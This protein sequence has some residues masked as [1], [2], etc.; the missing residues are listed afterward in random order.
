MR[1][2][3]SSKLSWRNA[4]P[5]VALLTTA[6]LLLVLSP[7]LPYRLSAAA[8]DLADGVGRRLANTN[9]GLCLDVPAA[10]QADGIKLQQWGCTG[11]TAQSW[12]FTAT[13]G[14]F[15]TLRN[16][17]S[18]KCLDVPYASP[19]P[20]TQLQQVVCNGSDAQNWQTVESATGFQVKNKANGLC[21]AVKDA[22]LTNT[23][24]IVQIACAGQPAQIWTISTL[25]NLADGVSR[26]AVNAN[27]GLCLDVPASSQA[28]GIKLQQWECNGAA[29]QN[30]TFTGTGDGFYT[31]KNVN[32]G[33]CLDVPYASPDPGTQLQQV[34]CNDADAQSWQ[35]LELS[36]GTR[37]KNKASNL[38]AAVKDAA[39]T[40]MA[41]IVQVA[42]AAG[43]AQLWAVI[44]RAPLDLADGVGRRAVNINSG[45]CLDVPASSQA[46]GIK[47][48]QW[49]CNGA[50]G[51]NW[52][53]TGT[54]DGFYTLK[55]VN[56]GKCLDVPYASPD[57]GTQLQQVV[58]NDADAQS[59]Q[60]LELSGGT[61]LKNKA[62]NLCAA[63]KDAALTNMAQII[64]IACATKDAQIW[65]ITAL[66]GL[67]G[68]PT[69]VQ[70]TAGDRQATVTW[71]APA[72][73]GG[74]ALTG[75]TVTAT[76]GGRTATVSGQATTAT[77]TGLTNGTNY[78]F[79]VVA[80]NAAG[81][82]PASQPSPGVTPVGP[83]APPTA[84]TATAGDRQVIVTWTAPADTGGS[85][86][87]GYTVTTTPGN[88]A[89]TVAG[90]TLT[91][92][93]TG[94]TNGTSYTF[95]VKAKN[96][97]GTGT[98][99]ASSSPATP[100]TTP[101]AP[102]NVTANGGDGKATVSWTAPADTG[103]SPITGYTVTTT[104]GGT[105]LVV[106][107]DRTSATVT[108]LAN[109]TT[110]TF[111]VTAR[112]T[113]GPGPE[114]AP[115][116]PVIPAPGLEAPTDVTAVPGDRQATVSWTAPGGTVTGY[117]ITAAPG[118]RTATVSGQATT[119]TVTGLTNGTAYTF[120]VVATN[121][122]T[123]GPASQPSTAVTPAGPPGAPTTVTVEGG[124][125][126]A[127]VSW[128]AP[129]DTGGKP[130]TG[131]TV[132][133]TPG[134]RTATVSGQ[135]TTATVTGLTNGTAYTFTVTAT[136]TAGTSEP[137]A[138]S[139]SVTPIGKPSPPTA[140]TA[141]AGDG[142]A[143]V[144][145]QAPVNGGSTI[146][147]YTVTATPGNATATVAGTTLTATVGG[148]TNGTAYTF[149][150]TATNAADTS[151]PSEPSNPVTP[152]VQAPPGAPFITDV[153]PR[154]GAVRVSWTPPDTGASGLTRYVVTATPGAASVETAPGATET[155]VTGL[156]NGTAY[157]F[158]VTAFN[159]VGEGS[160][161]WPSN[162][163]TP[164]P[165]KVPLRPAGVQAFP[166]DRRIDV[167]WVPVGD[168][169][170]PITG[171]VV[172]AQPGDV[173]VE[174]EATDTT[175]S[176][177]GLT[178]GTAYT[179]TV[180]ARNSAGDSTSSAVEAVTPSA[181]R[182]P[183]APEQVLVGVPT[184]GTA[185]ISWKPPVDTGTGPVTG[186]TVTA[187]PG[188]HS[189]TTS[190]ATT[191]ATVSGLNPET[192][193]AFTVRAANASGNG[194]ASGATGSIIPKVTVKRDP[195][196]L[197]QAALATLRDVRD[198]RTLV[199]HNPPAQVTGLTLGDIVIIEDSPHAPE[200]FL[201]K[202]LS[203][204]A[205]GEEFIVSTTTSSLDEIF[206][207]AAFAMD[208]RL[209]A[210]Q[211]EFI[212]SG[213][214]ARVA[215]AGP[216]TPRAFIR[217]PGVLVVDLSWTLRDRGRTTTQLNGW[218]TVDPSFKITNTLTSNLLDY[219][220]KVVTETSVKLSSELRLDHGFRRGFQEKLTLGVVKGPCF[221]VKIRGVPV[222]VCTRFYINYTVS[223][224]VS[225][226]LSYAAHLDREVGV[227]C[228]ASG[229]ATE[230]GCEIFENEGPGFW[231]D[232]CTGPSVVN[233]VGLYGDGQISTGIETD[234]ALMLYGGVGPALT[235]TF[236]RFDLKTSTTQNPWCELA[237]LVRVGA[238]L[239]ARIF[240]KTYSPW[241][242]PDLIPLAGK[243]LV[244]G[245]TFQGLKINP[246][247]GQVAPGLSLQFDA[248]VS[249][250]PDNV[251]K[252]WAV[253]KGPGTINQDGLYTAGTEQGV[254]E[255]EVVSPATGGHPELRARAAVEVGTVYG[256]PSAPRR[257][258]W[259]R[260]GQRSI[261]ASWQRPVSQGSSA[262]SGYVVIAQPTASDD[263]SDAITAYAPGN[264]THALVQNLAP[265]ETYRITVYARNAQ[266]TSLPSESEEITTLDLTFPAP[267]TQGN[268]LATSN[269]V[270]RG[271]PDSTN[272][273]LG[274]IS[275]DGRYLFYLTQGRSN[276][277]VTPVANPANYNLYLF[278]YDTT[279]TE[280]IVVS[281]G[282]TGEAVTSAYIF[283]A[284][285]DGNT[286]AFLN[287]SNLI[288][289]RINAGTS[290]SPGT[291]L[292]PYGVSNNGD[293][294]LYRKKLAGTTA[295]FNAFRQVAGGA[296]QQMDEECT[297]GAADEKCLDLGATM[298]DDGSKVAYGT[299][300]NRDGGN[301]WRVWVFDAA[302]GTR[303]E[304]TSDSAVPRVSNPIISGDG[305][306]VAVSYTWW[307]RSPASEPLVSGLALKR[308]GTG[309]VTRADI[310]VPFVS[311]TSGQGGSA[312]QEWA[313]PEVLSGDGQV[314]AYHH[315]T[316]TGTGIFD[317]LHSLRTYRVGGMT[318]IAG[319][320]ALTQPSL[321]SLTD[322]GQR[323]VYTLTGASGSG[324]GLIPGV[325]HDL[326]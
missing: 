103:G 213:P 203:A 133:A 117:T 24:Q 292:A 100:N 178:N 274:V 13:P 87:T 29:G 316:K 188:G 82:G 278:R 59:W 157:T 122:Q 45:L 164:E 152:A 277:A 154:D 276:L 298:S 80:A 9:S 108:G 67:P 227:R 323:L 107:A 222:K 287:G 30:W 283:K 324:L 238:A 204:A 299:I 104:P 138:P 77:V 301:E 245:D 25:V 8:A 220:P 102:T 131:Y 97:V 62:S 199:F 226:G 113:A 289:H 318:H 275:G 98:A 56:S 147:G 182:P 149:T 252:N 120:T 171:Y 166:L 320:S 261:T 192:A 232:D 211:M 27:S 279:T 32:S 111:T 264:A 173:T 243:S 15:Y 61:R 215:A 19:D 321:I 286:V 156:T 263:A 75:Y 280:R 73:T 10:S 282:L 159:T 167:Q 54:G 302:A 2:W 262:I 86:I 132:T 72:D 90:T 225:V 12:T 165:A 315:R 221:K 16:V 241:R 309:P 81:S 52:T 193:Y 46:D 195:V 139:A 207:D 326:L 200:G 272:S 169:G 31:L 255:I 236:P 297:T 49:E 223:G 202:V 306:T 53:F 305:S 240:N 106:T 55:N 325:W 242:N 109:G 290:W 224:E 162:P 39:L 63:V 214:G 124:D 308:L 161:S 33:K 65:A 112:T 26:R 270:P 217:P 89:T 186:Y 163:V 68:A 172:T 34:V 273:S 143:T 7:A 116:N 197:A 288:V 66:G 194:T 123:T 141:T 96:A 268:D 79:T 134:G 155:I 304:V 190:A 41:Q 70:G 209:D 228:T 64:Q 266:G 42:C 137:S 294:V 231:L 142:S 248:T 184:T 47:L 91:A 206:T 158:T 121:G 230:N 40:N 208:T 20:G 129:A 18:G 44:T 310:V 105:T 119:A 317:A 99:S 5:W 74:M 265:G 168:G 234:V 258:G 145:W 114:S 284:S 191:T 281:R 244:C 249:G 253:L 319:G 48:Q 257:D 95:T 218:V 148:L 151:E 187:A 140:V 128:T 210:D 110:Y 177:T 57:P 180:V 69:A 291:D 247:V 3:S 271:R 36:G 130:V 314:L 175:A 205:S 71:T 269:E 127:T 201:G 307:N 101:G 6:G 144:S 35:V 170:S 260:P 239:D 92:T 146:S 293:V 22:A 85:P 181:N 251:T 118:G 17:N 115:S 254:A 51:Q 300:D 267:I 43:D 285:R 58:C 28:D 212:P 229:T 250:Y 216:G 136:N 84:V 126:K 93:I 176:L 76:P 233:C 256:T 303:T 295:Q 94:L 88:T 246:Q 198:G 189:V 37:L 312:N 219:R 153:Y 125:G 235:F 14:G 50:A 60:V 135:T 1:G 38:C 78:T 11:A 183:G 237:G 259:S 23:A 4:L 21:M 185:E 179:V 150:V 160:A 174:V 196:L 83:P 313:T 311:D 296:P 322:D